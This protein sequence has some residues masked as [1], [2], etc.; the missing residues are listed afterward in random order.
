MYYLK[1]KKKFSQ[2]NG[3]RLNISI[4]FM[5]SYYLGKMYDFTIIIDTG[6]LDR[7]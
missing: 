3:N 6:V 4:F 5:Y 1:R 7:F 2:Q